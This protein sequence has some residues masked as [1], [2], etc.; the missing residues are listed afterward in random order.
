[1]S[2]TRSENSRSAGIY[3]R[4][5]QDREGA[6]PRRRASREASAAHWLTARLDGGRGYCD[7]DMKRVQRAA[8][9]R[10]R[11]H[12][13]DIKAGKINAVIAW[14]PDRL[15]RR[16]AELE[17]YIGVCDKHGVEN[18]TVTAGH[19]D[20]STADRQDGRPPDRQRGRLRD[21]STSSERI[22]VGAGQHAKQGNHHGGIRCYGYDQG[23]HHRHPRGSG[24]DRERVQG[25]RRAVHR[26]EAWCAT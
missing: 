17:R 12:A 8:P 10:V 22:K 1:M 25:H 24:R 3:V 14:H 13:R 6:G 7:N 15:H 21:R 20:L 4:I 23:R 9:P 19:W 11:T 18:Q 5:S 2:T 26:C 16:A